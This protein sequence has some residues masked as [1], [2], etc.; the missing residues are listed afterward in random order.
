MS[1]F[2]SLVIIKEIYTYVECADIQ[3]KIY[4]K[5]IRFGVS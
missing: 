1:K 4:K 2:I 3:H 5:S